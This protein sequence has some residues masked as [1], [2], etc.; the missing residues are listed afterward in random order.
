VDGG[1]TVVPFCLSQTLMECRHS[2]AH[3]QLWYRCIADAGGRR[4][5]DRQL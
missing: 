5:P 3:E 4:H 2:Q 1:D